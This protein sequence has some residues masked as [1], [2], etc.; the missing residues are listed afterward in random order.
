M[1]NSAQQ[2]VDEIFELY[3]QHGHHEYGESVTMMMHM[4]QAALIA[5]QE[6]YDDEMILAAFLHDIGH[7]FETEEQMHVYGTMKHDDLGGR[8]LMERGFPEKMA[9]LVASHVAAKRY[10]TFADP[11]YYDTLSEASKQTLGFQGGPMSAEEAAAFKSDPLFDAYIRIRI[12]DDMG[13]DANQPVLEEDIARLRY[14]T[15]QYLSA[16]A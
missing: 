14:K 7:F 15:Y 16:K 2:T 5:E 8:Y 1:S 9:K 12:W 11:A 4:M 13:K 3:Q 6:G 10:L